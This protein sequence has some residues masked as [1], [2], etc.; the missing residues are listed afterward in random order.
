MKNTDV[1]R[2]WS[3]ILSGYPPMLS[4]EITRECPLRCPGCYAYEPGHLGELGPLRSLADHK[5]QQLIDGVLALVRRYRPLHLSIVGGEPLV[6]FRELDILLPRLDKMGVEVQLVT[7]AVR[8]IPAEWAQIEALHLV[9]SIDGLQED[10]DR[11]RKP[12]TYERILQNIVGHSIIVHCTVT[13]QM[14]CRNKVDGK[15]FE[16]FLSFWSSRPEVRRIWFSLFT[17]QVGEELEEIIPAD[18]RAAVLSEFTRLRPLFPKLHLSDII[19]EGYRNP[20]KS[21]DQCIFART[22]LS[23]TADL[24][25]KITPCQFGG[26]PDCSQCG[27]IASAG[28]EAIGKYQL[29]GVLPVKSIY[30]ASDRIGKS[31]ARMFGR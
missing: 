16:D 20:P 12:A 22:T 9:V 10:H 6:R 4:I 30:F 15:Y 14:V 21:P 17:P 19:L 3:R 7:S 8:P 26:N 29:M 28:L 5:G 23:I 25:G 11:R 13:N 31:V 2:G 18:E 1:F 24:Q 27:C